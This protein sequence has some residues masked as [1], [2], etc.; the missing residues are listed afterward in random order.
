MDKNE[1]ILGYYWY[2]QQGRVR[3]DIYPE[4][5]LELNADSYRVIAGNDLVTL[6]K[7]KHSF[8]YLDEQTP[9]EFITYWMKYDYTFN[10]ITKEEAARIILTKRLRILS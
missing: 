4:G 10:K 6:D 2:M 5:I 3:K 8:K 1:D 9:K 7:R